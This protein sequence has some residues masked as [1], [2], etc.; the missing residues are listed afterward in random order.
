MGAQNYIAAKRRGELPAPPNQTL[1]GFKTN[2]QKPEPPDETQDGDESTDSNATIIQTPSELP[3]RSDSPP[4]NKGKLHIKKLSLHKARLVKKGHRLFRCIK[5]S[6][7]F[8]N[9]RRTE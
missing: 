8:S 6:M 7:L 3:D 5:C 4:K 2:V 1:P 9:D